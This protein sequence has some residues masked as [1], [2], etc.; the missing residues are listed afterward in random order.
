MGCS[1]IIS[2]NPLSFLVF[3]KLQIP[4]ALAGIFHK[5]TI[6][7]LSYP[8][9]SNKLQHMVAVLDCRY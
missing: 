9:Y 1:N 5:G 8:C 2:S 4:A 7:Q 3:S 6:F